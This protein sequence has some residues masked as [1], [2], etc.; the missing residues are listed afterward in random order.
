MLGILLH[1][2]PASLA[3]MNCYEMLQKVKLLSFYALIFVG[4][5]SFAYFCIR[6]VTL[7]NV[8][9]SFHCAHLYNLCIRNY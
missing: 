1:G 7:G 4:K 3:D 6:L 2:F 8:K 5:E 9:A